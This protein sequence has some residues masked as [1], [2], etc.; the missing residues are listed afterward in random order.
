MEA[1][2]PLLLRGLFPINSSPYFSLGRTEPVSGVRRSKMF[3]DRVQHSRQGSS[4]ANLSLHAGSLL[5]NSLA[6]R[7]KRSREIVSSARTMESVPVKKV[8]FSP[9]VSGAS[10][11][12]H[13]SQ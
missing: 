8:C 3:N 4:G 10:K 6:M 2:T 12:T 5:D 11:H 7:L 1:D 9:S 13:H